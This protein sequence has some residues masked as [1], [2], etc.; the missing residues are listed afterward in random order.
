MN[1]EIRVVF[2]TVKMIHIFHNPQL[3]RKYHIT[4][5]EGK[6]ELN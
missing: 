2:D 6:N 4:F 3:I 5:L 1:N